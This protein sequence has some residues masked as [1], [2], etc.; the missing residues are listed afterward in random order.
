MPL[1]AINIYWCH[2]DYHTKYLNMTEPS[3]FKQNINKNILKILYKK[4]DMVWN[5]NQDIAN[6]LSKVFSLQNFH[7]LPNPIDCNEVLKKSSEPCEDIFDKTKINIVML[8]RISK[9]KGFERVVRIMSNDIFLQRPEV[10]LYIIGDGGRKSIEKMISNFGITDRVTLLGAKS[11][12]Y[13]YLK[14]AQFLISPSIYESFGLVMMEAMLLKVPVITTA[15][16]GGKYI[17]Q[18]N[19]YA[20]CVE[21]DDT[22]LQKAIEEFLNDESS[23]KYSLEEAEQWVW[24]HDIKIFGEKILN[25]LD[26]CTKKRHKKRI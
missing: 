10:H 14:Q 17:T 3:S 20:R 4:H 11:N 19:K 26:E 22:A 18:N 23:Y 24:Q 9:E 6:G 12:P 8:G 7:A 21:N 16:T 5:V 13:P 15:T 1:F 25:L 2:N